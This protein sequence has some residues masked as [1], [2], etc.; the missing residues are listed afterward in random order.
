MDM[1]NDRGRH[2]HLFIR[3]QKLSSS[4]LLAVAV[5]DTL[6]HK[7]SHVP[8]EFLIMSSGERNVQTSRSRF[9][10]PMTAT[11]ATMRNPSMKTETSL[12]TAPSTISE[13]LRITSDLVLFFCRRIIF[14]PAQ[15]K[16]IVY[17]LLVLV[18]SFLKYLGWAPASYFSLKTNIF[19]VYF[20]KLGWGWT[21]GL[22]LPFVY[23]NLLRTH[24]Q[25]QIFKYHL[26]RFVVATGIWYLVTNFFIFLEAQTGACRQEGSTDLSKRLCLKSGYKWAEGHDISGHTFLFIYALLIINEE[27]KSYDQAWRNSKKD[28]ANKPSGDASGAANYSWT[29]PVIF[30]FYIALAIL[31][32]IWELML[33]STALYFHHTWH[34]LEAVAIAI[35]SWGL[36]YHLW[37]T[38]D[39]SSVFRPALPKDILMN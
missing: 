18:G 8:S 28:G 14:A 39:M 24:T 19:N 23:L 22:L 27:V 35:V 3:H 26:T 34:K 13:L 16:L 12:P 15:F 9:T 2:R 37:Y 7:D 33:L 5:T 36:T 11:T 10:P 1:T 29:S 30:L 25:Q 21:I 38:P 17:F 6:S 32:V 20:A 31:T 4:L